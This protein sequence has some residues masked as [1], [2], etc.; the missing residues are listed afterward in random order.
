MRVKGKWISAWL[1]MGGPNAK[2]C[3]YLLHGEKEEIEE[4]F[5]EKL[6]WRERPGQVESHVAL[7]LEPADPS[8]RN[9]WPRQHAWLRD[10]LEPRRLPTTGEAAR[11]DGV[12]SRARGQY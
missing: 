3:F 8:D 5:G 7:V 6:N 11:S 9:D 1:A 10:R 2:P 4:E 12:G